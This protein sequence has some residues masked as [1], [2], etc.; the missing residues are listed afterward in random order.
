MENGILYCNLQISVPDPDFPDGYAKLHKIN[1][2]CVVQRC[3]LV[4]EYDTQWEIPL[5]MLY[6]LKLCFM[7]MK[8]QIGIPLF[9]I[10]R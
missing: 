4:N 1:W 3:K 5:G 9:Q 2:D 6:I 7:Q 10:Y 8:F